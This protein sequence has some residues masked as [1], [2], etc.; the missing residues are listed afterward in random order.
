MRGNEEDA[1]LPD[2]HALA[3]E[4]GGSRMPNTGFRVLW[5]A[6]SAVGV[7]GD[8]KTHIVLDDK[9]ATL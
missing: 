1:P 5:F 9:S 6:S 2:L 7:L 3:P 4:P 8:S